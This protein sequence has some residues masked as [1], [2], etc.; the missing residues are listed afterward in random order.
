[1]ASYLIFPTTHSKAKI[2]SYRQLSST[3]R[4]KHETSNVLQYYFK[5]KKKN[6]NG[7]NDTWAVKQLPPE[8]Q[9]NRKSARREVLED[10][11]SLTASKHRNGEIFTS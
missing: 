3:I 8:V 2:K 10:K 7:K 9:L 11:K 6:T 4:V 1:M 5:T